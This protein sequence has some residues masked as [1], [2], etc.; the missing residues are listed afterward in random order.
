MK[1]FLTAL[2]F[3]AIL[4]L[5]GCVHVKTV[6][7]TSIPAARGQI[8]TAEGSRFM[9]LGISFNSDYIDETIGR[10]SEQCPS[11]KIDGVL[12]KLEV[13]DYFLFIVADERITA[14][15]FCR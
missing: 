14:R 7:L 10:L 4:S 3:I 8:V 1:R 2:S 6:S 15:G 11:G 13:V 5:P 12:T 9:F